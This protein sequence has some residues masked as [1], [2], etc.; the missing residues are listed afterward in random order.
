LSAI[1]FFTPC[2]GAPAS[3]LI[4]SKALTLFK[5]TQG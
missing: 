2:V 3:V 5:A 4:S 1:A